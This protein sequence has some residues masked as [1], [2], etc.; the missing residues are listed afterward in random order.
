MLRPVRPVS[1]EFLELTT[2]TH[3][4]VCPKCDGG[5]TR[6]K[7]LAVTRDAHGARWFCH[8]AGCGYK[9][10]IG[11]P[12]HGAEPAP[13]PAFTPRPL[14]AQWRFPERGEHWYGVLTAK[15]VL[16][17]TVPSWCARTGFRVLEADPDVAVWE[18]RNV[19]GEVTGHMTRSADKRIREWIVRPGPVYWYRGDR[20]PRFVWLFEDCM[21]AALASS[22]T[23]AVALLGTKLPAGFMRE[24]SVLNPGH[25]VVAL[26]P[27]AHDDAARITYSLAAAGFSVRV[28]LLST[29]FK[30]MPEMKRIAMVNY[31]EGRQT[32]KADRRG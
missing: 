19:A 28:C 15:G 18:L 4:L 9:G 14:D 2:G 22:E 32:P 1:R 11:K 25:V 20:S 10:G 26:D 29:D 16:A 17:P 13:A 21:S 3:R 31:Y 12:T 30:D 6:E 23:S 27:G 5:S 8:R 7:S 24:L